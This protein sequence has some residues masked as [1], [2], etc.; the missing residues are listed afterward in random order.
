MVDDGCTDGT[1]E[2]VRREF[3][4][5]RVVVGDGCLYWAGGMRLAWRTAMA[6][7]A[8][9]AFL[10][11]NDDV[12]LAGDFP[13]RLAKCDA[14]SMAKFGRGGIYAGATQDRETGHM[15][16]GGKRIVTNSFLLRTKW[17]E[18]CD[19]PVDC[20]LANANICYIGSGVVSEIGIFDDKF[21]QGI[22]DYDYSMNAK[23]RRI[24]VL[25]AP[26]FCGY[27]SNDHP[28]GSDRRT[29][30]LRERL[31]YLGSPKGL[32]YRSYLY[33]IR[34]HF[35][36]Y[37]PCAFVMLWFRTLF[38]QLWDCWNRCKKSHECKC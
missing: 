23:K 38:P 32:E 15:S 7:E 34:R 10:L 37:L 1:V 17:I 5:V 2:A 19:E 3:P 18:P 26:G 4:Q 8:Y 11:I 24:P 6:T 25:L 9:E 12:T 14:Y 35:P 27:C 29:G 31:K 20:D 22:A 13:L 30:G 33:Y 16:Y 36:L 28:T 21:V